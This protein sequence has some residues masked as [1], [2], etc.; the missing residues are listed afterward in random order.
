MNMV[1]DF[2]MYTSNH[3]FFDGEDPIHGMVRAK[4]EKDHKLTYDNVGGIVILYIEGEDY[5]YGQVRA[6][7]TTSVQE[8]LKLLSILEILQ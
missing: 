8:L 5:I 3:F 1:E 2:F 4:V 6:C 7:I